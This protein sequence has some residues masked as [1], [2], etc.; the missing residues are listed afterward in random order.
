MAKRAFLD[1]YQS[2]VATALAIGGTSLVLDSVT[3]LAAQDVL[4][5][6]EG[7]TKAE[8]VF[9]TAVTITTKTATIVKGMAGTTDVAHAKG[10]IV[11]KVGWREIVPIQL[12]TLATGETKAVLPPKG[13]LVKASTVLEAAI[14][15]G[16]AVITLSKGSQEITGGAITIDQATGDL[17]TIDE[18]LPT[19]YNE[20]NGTTDYLKAVT[21][22]SCTSVV[23]QVVLCEFICVED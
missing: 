14:A 23:D 15:A 19:L 4:I 6:D 9:V 12:A 7:N 11:K 16:D 13:I 17:G 2:R 20:F 1:V 10:A 18:C 21:S 3:G 5:I 22:G 8:V